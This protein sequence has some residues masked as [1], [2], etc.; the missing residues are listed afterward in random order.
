MKLEIKELTGF[1]SK[2]EPL[3]EINLK[4]L[5]LVHKPASVPSQEPVYKLVGSK[6]SPLNPT[7]TAAGRAVIAVAVCK[8]LL[9]DIIDLV[10]LLSFYREI[11]F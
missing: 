9:Y 11:S 3:V 2:S 4:L 10:I 8:I 1:I 7:T 5:V 6:K